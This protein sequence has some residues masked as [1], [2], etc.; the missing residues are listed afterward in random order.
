MWMYLLHTWRN[1]PVWTYMDALICIIRVCTQ[2]TVMI[3]NGKMSA[4]SI[5][6]F[7][8]LLLGCTLLYMIQNEYCVCTDDFRNAISFEYLLNP[9]SI[10]CHF[11]AG[12]KSS[13]NEWFDI[14]LWKI[15][16]FLLLRTV[17]DFDL[18]FHLE[19]RT[20]WKKIIQIVQLRQV[21]LCG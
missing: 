4:Y 2:Y 11:N 16:S 6:F 21:L 12:R 19:N 9:Q 10:L 5:V 3:I 13:K 17:I 1:T 14:F 20:I 18:T 15:T 7:L 8:L